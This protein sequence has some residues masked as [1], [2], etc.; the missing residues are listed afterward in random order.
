MPSFMRKALVLS[1]TTAPA[2]TAAGANSL[3]IDPPAEKKAICTPLNASLVNSSTTML[4]PSNST[5]FPALRAEANSRRLFMGNF[6][7]ASTVR[8]SCPT[9][10]VAPTIATF[11]DIAWLPKRISHATQ[12]HLQRRPDKNYARWKDEDRSSF[13]G[14]RFP[15]R[16][17][18]HGRIRG[19]NT[20]YKFRSV[21]G[22]GRI[23]D[24]RSVDCKLSSFS[25]GSIIPPTAADFSLE[26]RKLVP[27][28]ARRPPHLPGARFS[29]GRIAPHELSV[30]CTPQRPYQPD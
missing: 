15:C 14:R 3:L 28:A 9:A 30:V 13:P 19:C 10:P 17:R 2:A 24:F 25:F 23:I 12:T 7:S 21:S 16:F 22:C 5:V 4:L 29:F 27:S 20:I 26:F 8:N 11:T 18:G 6:R 1:I